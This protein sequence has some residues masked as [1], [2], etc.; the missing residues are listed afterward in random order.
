MARAVGRLPLP[1]LAAGSP[2]L[3]CRR[4]RGCVGACE[5]FSDRVLRE[6]DSGRAQG[7][8]VSKSLQ[9]GA[10]ARPGFGPGLEPQE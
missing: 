9:E 1:L 6:D 3:L 2:R 7:V 4:R 5:G 8:G 10:C